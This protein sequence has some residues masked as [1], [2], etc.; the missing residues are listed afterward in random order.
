MNCVKGLVSVV[1]LMALTTTAA[2]Q[3]MSKVENTPHNLANVD[4]WGVVLPQNR[5]CL[6]CHISHNAILDDAGQSQA[7]WNHA[8]TEQTFQMY[9]TSTGNPVAQPEGASKLCLSCHDGATALDSFGN[10]EGFFNNVLIPPDRPSNLGTDLRDDHPIGVEY[11]PPDLLG[12][13]DKSTFTG[14]R[15]VTIDGVDRV[16]CT[17]C[18]DAHDN[19][20]GMFLLQTVEGSALCKECHDK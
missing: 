3:D 11:P 6:P 13:K 12:Y 1:C 17:S 2:A 8:M 19:T 7:L 9:T 5:V 4:V 18:H 14:V 20:F 16:E 15:V 10:N